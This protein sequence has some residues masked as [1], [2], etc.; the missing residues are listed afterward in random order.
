MNL[1]RPKQSFF[2]CEYLVISW[3]PI[4]AINSF[5]GSTESELNHSIHKVIKRKRESESRRNFFEFVRWG[6]M[7]HG[8]WQLLE[9]FMKEIV[10]YDKFGMISRLE[11]KK[12][13]G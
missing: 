4:D 12:K 2:E 5:E 3:T 6:F 9:A 13:N 11:L 8:M 1:H 10:K 7:T